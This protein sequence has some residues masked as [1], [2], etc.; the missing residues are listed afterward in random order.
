LGRSFLFGRFS[1]CSRLHEA[2]SLFLWQRLQGFVAPFAMLGTLILSVSGLFVKFHFLNFFPGCLFGLFLLCLLLCLLFRLSRFL[3]IIF[4]WGVDSVPLR[5]DSLIRL[6]TVAFIPIVT[7]VPVITPIP[8]VA[9]V[10]APLA[11]RRLLF[12]ELTGTLYN[13]IPLASDVYSW[14]GWI[15]ILMYEFTFGFDFELSLGLDLLN[16]AR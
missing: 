6:I 5:S 2:H 16:N 8:P 3:R 12:C 4:G 1:S 13:I 10:L 15:G 14:V 9:L 7:P 11:F